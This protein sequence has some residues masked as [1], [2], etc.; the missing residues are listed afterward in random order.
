MLE[1]ALSNHFNHMLHSL[2]S[3]NSYLVIGID[4]HREDC[5]KQAHKHHYLPHHHVRFVSK[6]PLHT[7]TAFQIDKGPQNYELISSHTKCSPRKGHF[8]C[9]STGN[10][11]GTG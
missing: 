11:G 6:S 5:P 2:S 10:E 8:G 7:R 4:T 1:Y 9:V 3:F